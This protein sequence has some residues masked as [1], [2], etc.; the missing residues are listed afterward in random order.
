LTTPQASPSRL[1]LPSPKQLARLWPRVRPH[2]KALA[3]ATVTLLLSAAIGLAFPM[4]VGYLLDSAFVQRDRD[5]LDRVALGLLGLFLIQAVL[6]Y[7]QTYLLSATGERAVAGL[8]R[9][10][11]AKLLEMPPGF[12]A[13]RRTGELTSRLTTDIGLLQGVL[14]HQIA[15]FSRQI[16]ALV[17]GVAILTWMQPQLTLTALGVVPI[18]VGTAMFFGRRLRRISTGVQDKV[19]DATAVAEEA[20][21]QIRT[22]QSFVQEPAE[23]TRYGEKVARVVESALARAQVRGVFFGAITFS[24]FGGIVIVLWQ[25]GRLVL[26]G[27]LTAGT[28]VSFLL[29]TATIAA[30]VGALASFFS[31]YQESVGAAE[32]V[33]ELLEAPAQVADPLDPIP[34][35][36][37]VRGRVDLEQVSFRY[38]DVPD[39][40]WALRDV[41]FTLEPGEVVAIVGP[42]G[43]GKTTLVSLLSRFWDVTEGRI[44]LDGTD[45][46]R[47]RLSDLRGAI[48]TVPQEPA[49]FSGTVHENIAYARPEASA[50]EIERAARAAHAHEFVERLP[51]GYD[52]VVGERGIK[53]S[54]G[55]RQRIAIA[56]AVLKDPAVL[57]LDEATSSLDTESER[58]VEDALEKLLVGRTTLIIAHRLS[59]V[60][61]ADRLLVLS[62]GRITEQG[63][64]AELLARGGLYARLYQRQFRDGDAELEPAAV[65]G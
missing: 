28:L 22:V 33:F 37:P 44:R 61:R 3:L 57:V 50:G 19:A 10:L 30:A 31:S 16:L 63:T 32:R 17:G 4:V 14:S 60:R 49:L 46:R 2:R 62:H 65:E 35:P 51:K 1:H 55:Q 38:H 45:I 11:F 26:D 43:G 59:T 34:L 6:N 21:S 39:A 47:L 13:D 23:R 41:S 5:T 9:E 56:R 36:R 53:L 24:T 15:E 42:S 48:G 8:R 12:F 27:S 18:V 58:L 64:H 52:T 7:A 25:G 54:G 29:Y 20:F 40:P